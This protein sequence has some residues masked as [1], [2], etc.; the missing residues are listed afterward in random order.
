MS[1]P[2][3]LHVT[4]DRK[5]FETVSKERLP[6]TVTAS[7]AS[8]V[9]NASGDVVEVDIGGRGMPSIAARQAGSDAGSSIPQAVLQAEG[10]QQ[11]PH[12]ASILPA[13]KVFS[14]QIGSELF[15]LSGVS[16]RSDAPSYFSQFFEEQFRQ[17]EDGSVGLKTLYIDRDPV[18]FKD[19]SRHL[20]G[21]HVQPR[22]GGHFVR[23]FA[24]AQFYSLPRLISQLFNSEIFIQIG[25]QHFQVPRDIFSGPGD[26]PNFFSLGFAVFFSTPGEVFPGLDHK[27]LVRPPSILPPS[28][29]NRSGHV[30]A[31]LLQM[32]RG[33]PLHIRNEEHR[34]E[35]LRDCRYFHLRGLEQKLIPHDIGYNLER[36]KS[37]ITIRLEDIRQ[38]GISFMGDISPADRSPLGGWVYYARPFVDE[39][40]QELILEIG[41]DSTKIDFR[42]MRADFHGLAKARVSSLFQVVANKL[43]LP[44]NAP[45][46]LMMMSGGAATQPASPGNTPLSQ[47]RVKISIERDAHVIL[48]GD[49]YDVDWT[50]LGAVDGIDE[51]DP[52]LLATRASSDYEPPASVSG[53]LSSTAGRSAG[54]SF[55]R[56]APPQNVSQPITSPSSTRPPP[57]KRKRVGS[58]DDFGEWIVR[59]GQW[60]LKVQASADP[61]KCDLEIILIAV[62]LDALSGERGRNIRRAFLS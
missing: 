42:S 36:G 13:E 40:S 35:L 23:L 7:N 28:V 17:H 31:E 56:W 20:Q 32:L 33:Y 52:M 22:D 57:R 47:D 55:Q 11:V 21:Y 30:F 1:K 37:E 51:A 26:S 19:I 2:N 44:T 41:G 27:G 39:N 14:I 8:D 6:N 45:L 61:A 18:T 34:A 5:I 15:R 29:P 4:G 49:N 62:K 3:Q 12:A 43:N 24:D 38:S 50:G 48:D 46:G 60:R 59:R 9:S 10:I 58:L 53:G 25:H 16:I 54:G